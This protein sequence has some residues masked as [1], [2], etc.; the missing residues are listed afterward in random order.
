MTT[1]LHDHI[2]LF[3]YASQA[4]LNESE[5]NACAYQ[6]LMPGL[7]SKLETAVA[8]ERGLTGVAHIYRTLDTS[9]N[10]KRFENGTL[11]IMA[12]T[13]EKDVLLLLSGKSCW[14]MLNDHDDSPCTVGT[15]NGY[16]V[17]AQITNYRMVNA[18][19][20]YWYVFVQIT[21]VSS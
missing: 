18:M 3:A 10:P 15:G 13:A 7:D 16:L 11:Q 9:N 5:Q 1:A 17:V 4:E 21:D 14:L 6:V 19:H 20:D 2:H 8:V 12:T